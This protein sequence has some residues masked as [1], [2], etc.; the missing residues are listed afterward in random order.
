MKTKSFSPAAGFTALVQL[1]FQL[2][3]CTLDWFIS[4]SRAV[5]L[6]LFLVS[7]FVSLVLFCFCFAPDLGQMSNAPIY[8]SGF[9]FPTGSYLFNSAAFCVTSYRATSSP[10]CL[11]PLAREGL[12]FSCLYFRHLFSGCNSSFSSSF[13]CCQWPICLSPP[14]F[15]PLANQSACDWPCDCIFNF[16][17]FAVPTAADLKT[18]LTVGYFRLANSS[19]S[20][21]SNCQQHLPLNFFSIFPTTRTLLLHKWSPT[22]IPGKSACPL[23]QQVT[24]TLSLL[25]PI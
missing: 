24:V 21:C 4:E 20:S 8:L 10:A 23:L 13:N 14:H 1:D 15:F 18:I 12:L 25:F 19:I 7:V 9:H 17:Y 5:C 11:W 3:V 6:P 22:S 2:C 16:N